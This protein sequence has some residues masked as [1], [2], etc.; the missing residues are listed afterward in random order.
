VGYAAWLWLDLGNEE[1]GADEQGRRVGEFVYAY[2]SMPLG[3]GL[4]AV[5]DA[6][7]E[8]SQRGGTPS[9][10]REW[11]RDCLRWTRKNE[12]AL[13]RG[14]ASMRQGAF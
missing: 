8:L 11:A 13:L 5:L 9:E 10:T 6:Q 14:L 3:D 7:A 12:R 2:G 1:L 4:S